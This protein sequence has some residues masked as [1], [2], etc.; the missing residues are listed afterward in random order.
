M[1]KTIL[2][3][4]DFDEMKADEYRCW[5]S[6]PIHERVAAVWKNCNCGLTSIIC[7]RVTFSLRAAIDAGRFGEHIA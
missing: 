5:E 1:A 6:L 3:Y 2:K 4:T 7:S